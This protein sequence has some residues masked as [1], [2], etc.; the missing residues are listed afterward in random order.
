MWE[1]LV[2]WALGWDHTK[3]GVKSQ[4]RH[5][6]ASLNDTFRKTALSKSMAVIIIVSKSAFKWSGVKDVCR[7]SMQPSAEGASPRETQPTFT[8]LKNMKQ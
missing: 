8:L 1:T 5:M 7:A 3:K 6:T 4:K 2:L